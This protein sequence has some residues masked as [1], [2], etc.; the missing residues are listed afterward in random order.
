MQLAGAPAAATALD[1][2]LVASV[3]PS[4]RKPLYRLG[5]PSWRIARSCQ[6]CLKPLHIGTAR[7][8]NKPAKAGPAARRE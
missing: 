3:R 8:G 7:I 2:H 6:R 5:D 1:R 4:V